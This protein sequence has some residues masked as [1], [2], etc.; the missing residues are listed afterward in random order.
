MIHKVMTIKHNKIT[1]KYLFS[2]GKKIANSFGDRVRA[3]RGRTNRRYPSE[4]P[5]LG[6][7][8]GGKNMVVWWIL[9]NTWG[10]GGVKLELGNKKT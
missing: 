10:G 3:G 6:L 2:N 9:G 5:L 1:P 4:Y 7:I 8:L